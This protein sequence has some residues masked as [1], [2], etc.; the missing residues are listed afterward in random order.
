MNAEQIK[1]SEELQQAVSV[2]ETY[3]R[4]NNNVDVAR[5]RF[6]NTPTPENNKLCADAV[7]ELARFKSDTQTIIS[8]LDKLIMLVEH[9]D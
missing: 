2:V 5:K 8:A 6:D 4:L 9:A 3:F 7:H 1:L